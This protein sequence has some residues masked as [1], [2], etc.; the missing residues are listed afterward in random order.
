MSLIFSALAEIDKQ[1]QGGQADYA[2]M[3]AAAAPWYARRGVPALIVVLVLLVL[4]LGGYMLYKSGT[5]ARAS[6]LVMSSVP[7]TASDAG[8]GDA[9]IAAPAGE[10][11]AAGQSLS[12]ASMAPTAPSAGQQQTVALEQDPPYAPSPDPVVKPAAPAGSIPVRIVNRHGAMSEREQIAAAQLPIAPADKTAMTTD[13]SAPASHDVAKVRTESVPAHGEAQQGAAQEHATE[14]V[15][16]TA[17][18]AQPDQATRTPS[19]ATRQDDAPMIG[20][21]NYIKV[22][23][24]PQVAVE[25]DVS[26]W[27]AAFRE[28]MAQGEHRNAR[29]ALARL[30]AGLS[31]QS[32]TLLRMK[33]WYAVDSGDDAAARSAYARVLQ[34][35]PDDI[36]AGV[37]VALIDWR[38][39]RHGEALRQINSMYT[40]HPD[41]DLVKRNW[42]VM[43]QQRR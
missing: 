5:H 41:S 13:P 43:H 2:A 28:A 19:P 38:A 26:H 27:V 33:A 40:Q 6:A 21:N 37:N 3:S 11:T 15:V 25:T 34:R 1:A 9:Q 23:K 16:T 8:S 10:A 12:P 17:Q 22:G 4:C 7:A 24:Q 29:A 36:N 14:S 32:L 31:P 20:S 39:G 30:E 42:Q 35:L 18:A